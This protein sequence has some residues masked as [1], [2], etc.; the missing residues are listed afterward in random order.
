[1]AAVTL[2]LLIVGLTSRFIQY[3][4]QAVAGEL[5]SDVLF[6]LMLYRLPDFLLVI[7]PLALFLGILLAYGRMYAENEMVILIGSGFSQFRLLL[8]TMGTSMLVLLLVAM[9]SLQLAP[10]GVRNTEQLKQSQELLTEVDLIVAGQFQ[11]FGEGNRVTYA[12]RIETGNDEVRQLQ[13]VFVA[14][15]TASAEGGQGSPRIIIAESARPEVDESTG[16]RFMRLENVLQ[17]DGTPGAADFSIGQFDVQSILLP[18]AASFEPILEEA[19]LPTSALIGSPLPEHQ[20]ELQW[21]IS[22][23]LLIPIITLIA[24]PLSKVDPRQGRYSKLVPAALLYACYFVL[25]QIS[26]DMVADGELSASIGLW[27]VHALFVGIGLLIYRYPDIGKYFSFG[28]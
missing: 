10:W 16:A 23:L 2:I 9:L 18:E 21:R 11:S 6:L 27:W 28:R 3:L 19:T 5:A 26:R 25:L 13:N 15:S 22:M 20:A 7:L 4:A 8:T 12:E 24:V 17:Y 1:M 14:V